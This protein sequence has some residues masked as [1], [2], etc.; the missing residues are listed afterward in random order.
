MDAACFAS[1][2]GS[3]PSA[4]SRLAAAAGGADGSTKLDY[5]T[6]M[7]KHQIG[8]VGAGQMARA[9]AS[10]FVQAGLA[11]GSDIL[12]FD[13]SEAAEKAFS[14]AVPGAQLE[15][16][17]ADV[18]TASDIV[19]LA[20]KPQYMASAMSAVRE[21]VTTDTLFVSIAAGIRLETLTA[22]LRSTRVIR[23][24]PNTP[25]LV[26]V[27]AAGFAAGEGA[28]EEDC[29]LVNRLLS[30][31]GLA[32][33][34][35]ERLLD[36]VTGLS[37]SGPAFVYMMIEAFSDGGVLMG[38]PRETALRLAAQMVKGAAEMV[39]ETG[40]HPGVLK[41][42]V[43][44]PAGTT[45]AGIQAMEEGAVRAACIRAVQAAS[46]RSEELASVQ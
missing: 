17:N 28:T 14:E 44:S 8:F 31:I 1:I 10:G 46:E 12:A 45:I 4:P 41:D 25:A 9:L 43:A 11:D 20:V 13:P 26:G 15:V 19:F 33:E 22:E 40:Q 36:A 21:A 42:H 16:S 6:S 30:A 32:Y 37:G 39:L 29:Q 34:V 35:P 3:W 2:R 7:T 38:L 24:M 23:V 5:P 27:G 18:V